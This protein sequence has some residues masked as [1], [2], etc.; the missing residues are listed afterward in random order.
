MLS[1]SSRDVDT[2]LVAELRATARGAANSRPESAG[3]EAA[4]KTLEAR[5]GLL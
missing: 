3:P 5:L 1:G 2:L 4:L